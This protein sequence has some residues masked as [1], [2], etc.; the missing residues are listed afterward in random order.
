MTLFR[1][2]IHP[3]RIRALMCCSTARA[4]LSIDF[5]AHPYIR[6]IAAIWLKGS[7]LQPCMQGEQCNQRRNKEL[8]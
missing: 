3:C 1:D 7:E 5:G 2:F 4:Q 8:L 6:E